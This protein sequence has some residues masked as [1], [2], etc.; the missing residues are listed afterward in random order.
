ML[1][2][3]TLTSGAKAPNSGAYPRRNAWNL[4]VFIIAICAWLAII[5]TAT[6]FAEKDFFEVG[7]GLC[8]CVMGFWLLR[9]FQGGFRG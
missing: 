3:T 1:M 7:L 6:G 4:L 8:C 5:M 2:K 9:I